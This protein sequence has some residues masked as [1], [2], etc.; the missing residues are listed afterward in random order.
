MGGAGN[1]AAL[2][3]ALRGAIRDMGLTGIPIAANYFPTIA[4]QAS[5]LELAGFRVEQAYWFRRPTPLEKGTT[6]ADWTRHFR[7]ATWAAVPAARHAEFAQSIDAR[8]AERGLL[9]DTGWFA[10]YCR[11]RFV[12]VA[13]GQTGREP[14]T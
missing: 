1:I 9:T 3:A 2:D 4:Q 10:D 12:A 13:T 5:V 6:A 8:A 14:L 7:A 11:L